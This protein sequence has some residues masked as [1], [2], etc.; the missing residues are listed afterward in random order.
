MKAGSD[1]DSE[2][3]GGNDAAA[4]RVQLCSE[5]RVMKECFSLLQAGRAT[6]P[7]WRCGTVGC[8]FLSEVPLPFFVIN[9][10]FLS[11]GCGP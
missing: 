3:D 1:P 4:L 6:W 11:G 2:S 7:K 9:S 5:L 10:E 8:V